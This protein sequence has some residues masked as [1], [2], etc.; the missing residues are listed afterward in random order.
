[1]PIAGVY[2]IENIYNGKMYIGSSFYA[3]QR[4][5]AHFSLLRN[6]KSHNKH[7]QASYNK[8]GKEAFI[9]Y[10]LEPCEK[11][12]VKEREQ[13][14][15]D[16]T[17][18]ITHGFNKSW[19]VIDNSGWNHSEEL[20][21]KL[22]IE[23]KGAGNPAYG[24]KMTAEEIE[25]IRK[26][27]TGRKHKKQ[28]KDKMIKHRSANKQDYVGSKSGKAILNETK[29]YEIKLLIAEGELSFSEIALK[30]GIAAP[31]IGGIFTGTR[32]GHVKCK[33]LEDYRKNYKPNTRASGEANNKSKL[34]VKQVL[35]IRAISG[36]SYAAIGRMYNVSDATISNIIKMKIWRNATA[37]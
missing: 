12:V 7:L 5:G 6:N 2:C 30:Y 19:T 31:T 33:P 15:I 17:N 9:G 27:S 13:F 1:M 11:E 8:Y 28:A 29:V 36:K 25:V 16:N 34:T 24:K 10:V 18:C 4:L 14:W 35:E 23:R 37:V 21:A 3:Q 22:S 20:K 26:N 32:W